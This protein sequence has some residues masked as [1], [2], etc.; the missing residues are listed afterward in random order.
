MR[1][2]GNAEI[3]AYITTG[4]PFDKAGA[5]AIQHPEFR[6]VQELRGC[7]SGV[8]GLPLA[9]LRDLL[10]DFGVDVRPPLPP[11][12]QAHTAFICCQTAGVQAVVV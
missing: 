5:Y 10:A 11:I 12:C 4:D 3:A 6:P 1:I 2:Y 9:E 7:I 8:M